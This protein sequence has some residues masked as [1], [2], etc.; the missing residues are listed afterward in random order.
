[1]LLYLSQ[2]YKY[3]YKNKYSYI[4][5]NLYIT[6]YT[7]YIR[8]YILFYRDILLVYMRLS[9]NTSFGNLLSINT[10]FENYISINS[11]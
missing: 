6:R 3:I 7:F 11:I 9:Y 4:I 10:D 1:M 5:L 8:L 2:Q